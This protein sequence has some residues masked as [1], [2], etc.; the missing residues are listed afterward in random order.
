VLLGA[1]W[2]ILKQNYCRRWN[3]DLPLHPR[4]HGWISDLEASSLSSQK[5]VQDSAL[6]KESDY[7]F[8]VC[9]WIVFLRRT[10]QIDISLW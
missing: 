2:S 1:W 10:W 6:S 8:L 4:E 5:A 7:C 3:L 9:S